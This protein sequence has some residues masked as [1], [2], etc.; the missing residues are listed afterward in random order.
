[1]RCEQS[2]KFFSRGPKPRHIGGIYPPHMGRARP[3]TP[4]QNPILDG[5]KVCLDPSEHTAHLRECRALLGPSKGLE[6]GDVIDLRL[7]PRLERV[8]RITSDILDL[9]LHILRTGLD[10]P[11]SLILDHRIQR[12]RHVGSGLSCNLGHD[13]AHDVL[14]ENRGHDN[15]FHL[16]GLAMSLVALVRGAAHSEEGEHDPDDEGEASEIESEL[17]HG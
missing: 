3:P 5:L 17:E 12:G 8:G 6:E 11:V 10:H 13:V 7:H 16:G 15:L 1:M 9:A 4:S 14:R 2:R